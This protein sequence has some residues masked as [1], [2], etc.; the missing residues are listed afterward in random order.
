MSDILPEPPYANEPAPTCLLTDVFEWHVAVALQQPGQPY[1]PEIGPPVV[2]PE[3][4]YFQFVFI[5][6]R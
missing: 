1:G 5:F 2:L 3:S 6:F 4:A